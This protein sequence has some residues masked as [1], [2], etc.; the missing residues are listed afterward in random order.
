MGSQKSR[1]DNVPGDLKLVQPLPQPA[2][3]IAKLQRNPR[4]A[5]DV[6][7]IR[8]QSECANEELKE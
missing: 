6:R 2:T 5:L 1:F 7:R 3:L 8:S 4:H